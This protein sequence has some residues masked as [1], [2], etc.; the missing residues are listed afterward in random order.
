MPFS[1]VLSTCALSVLCQSAQ[2]RRA[3]SYADMY[4]PQ[5]SEV[6]VVKPKKKKAPRKPKRKPISDYVP[7]E[8]V[9]EKPAPAPVTAIPS[10]DHSNEKPQIEKTY[11]DK[12]QSEKPHVD[13]E[14]AKK[15]FPESSDSQNSKASKST[16]DSEFTLDNKSSA[17]LEKAKHIT[18]EELLGADVVKGMSSK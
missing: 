3:Y 13:K 12:P 14:V 15:S 17:D 4:V 5:A 16:T 18:L 7:K 1:L 2:A 9:N 8:V 6:E 10:F 11:S